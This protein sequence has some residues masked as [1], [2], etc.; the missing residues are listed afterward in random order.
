MGVTIIDSV[1]DEIRSQIAR[2]PPESGGALYGPRG[3]ALITHFEFDPEA[4]TSAVSYIPSTRLIE[5]VPGVESRTGLQFK[6]IV[7]SHPN[8]FVQ[9]SGGDESTVAT[10]F[11]MNPHLSSIELPIVQQEMGDREILHWYRVD[12]GGCRASGFF[13]RQAEVTVIPQEFF[14]LPLFTDFN[15]LLLAL[16]EIG[17]DLSINPKLQTLRLNNAN[18][19]GVSAS[20]SGGHEVHFYTSMDYPVLPPLIL[21]AIA[22]EME[23]VNF[24]WSATESAAEQLRSIANVLRARWP[25]VT[26]TELS[27]DVP[28]D[29]S[30]VSQKVYKE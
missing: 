14:I 24:E 16:R 21:S 12:R 13:S 6:G 9:P 25:I 2:K 27:T 8:G 23:Q 28:A 5:N 1:V 29:A 30:E 22:A 11:R 17:I 26:P 4:S 19:V 7:H 15:V 10:F 18:F 3:I 20:G